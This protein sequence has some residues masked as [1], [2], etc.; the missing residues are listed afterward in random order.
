MHVQ[1]YTPELNTPTYNNNVRTQN[2]VFPCT[3]S[4]FLNTESRWNTELSGTLKCIEMSI[5]HWI[6]QYSVEMEISTGHVPLETMCT[7]L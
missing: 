7:T 2:R 3:I 4:T 5:V 1:Y 6:V